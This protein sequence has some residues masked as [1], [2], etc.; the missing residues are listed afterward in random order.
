MAAY[1][2]R[3]PTPGSLPALASGRRSTEP[4]TTRGDNLEPK[5]GVGPSRRR[6]ESRS[7]GASRDRLV[8]GNLWPAAHWSAPADRYR[9]GLSLVWVI[10]CSL[11]SFSQ[12]LAMAPEERCSTFPKA[13]GVK[14]WS[15]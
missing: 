10:S 14:S 12:A 7:W 2:R 11:T 3:Q 4:A 6:E 1:R 9:R 13:D 15:A 8:V 5:D